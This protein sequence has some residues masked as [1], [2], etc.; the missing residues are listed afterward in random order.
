[1][2]FRS[3]VLTAVATGA[4]NREIADELCLTQRTVAAHVEAILARLD[5]PSRAGAAA[6]ATAAGVLLPSADPASKSAGTRRISGFW[7]TT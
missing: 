1:M 3:E 7:S 6:K 2:L 5:S 4:G